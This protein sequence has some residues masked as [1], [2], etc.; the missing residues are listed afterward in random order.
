MSLMLFEQRES[1]DQIFIGY[2]FE[3]DILDPEK[4]GKIYDLYFDFYVSST[5]VLYNLFSL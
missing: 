2:M 5:Q 3:A 1:T 4:L